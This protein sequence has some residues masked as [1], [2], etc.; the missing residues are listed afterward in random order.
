[1]ESVARDGA[2]FKKKS[3]YAAEQDSEANQE[4]RA[5][6]RRK[7][8]G[9]DPEKLIFMDESGVTTE[10]TRRYG[11]ARGG[12]RLR[13]GVPAGHWRTLSVLGAIR[14]SG[15][16]AAMTIEA[17]TDGEVFLAYLERVLGPQ[18]RP[19]DV[20]V[21]DN[22]SAHKVAGVRETIEAHGA[23][24]LYLPPYSPDFNPIE[25]CWAQVKQSLRAAKARALPRL[26]E[27]LAEALSKVT[28]QNMQACFQHCGYGI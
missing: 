5:T 23:Q 8:S 22:L 4:R 10:M 2:A 20:V 9:I 27:C 13:E 17:A 16:V 6:W 12:R 28:P 14:R 7:V 11:R 24:L 1:M 3:L 15:W 21:M 19:G 26:E 25:Q 18:L